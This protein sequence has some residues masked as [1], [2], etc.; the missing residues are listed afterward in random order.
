ML[1]ANSLAALPPTF[2]RVVLLISQ[3]GDVGSSASLAGVL[4]SVERN[5]IVLY[6]LVM[7]RFG[8]DLASRT[9]RVGGVDGVFGP[10][11]MGIMGSVDLGKLVTEI[12]RGSKPGGAQ[13]VPGLFSAETGGS[14]IPFRRLRDLESGISSIAE[15]LYTEYLLTYSPDATEPGYHHI[16]VEVSRAGVSARWRPGYYVAR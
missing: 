5:N 4:E 7:R 1:A 11:D 12:Q 9:V 14:R 10:K 16:R 8:K 6:R 2:R 15:E 13:D 3:P